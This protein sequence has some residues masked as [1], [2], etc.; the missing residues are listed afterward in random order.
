MSEHPNAPQSPN[1][2]FQFSKSVDP[3]P[4]SSF[5]DASQYRG[6]DLSACIAQ[7]PRAILVDLPLASA[8]QLLASKAAVFAAV[9]VSHLRPVLFAFALG[10]QWLAQLR[11]LRGTQGHFF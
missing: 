5:H 10:S 3:E 4:V 2:E 11:S 7:C 1:T 9:P 8:L 6:T